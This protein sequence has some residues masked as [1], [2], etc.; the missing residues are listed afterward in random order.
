MALIGDDVLQ[1]GKTVHMSLGMLPLASPQI[2][3]IGPLTP[4]VGPQTPP[5]NPQTSLTGTQTPP[6]GLQIALAGSV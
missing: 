2:F 4:L 1:N 6:A 3:L 5:A